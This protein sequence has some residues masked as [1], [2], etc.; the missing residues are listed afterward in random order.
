[1][2]LT[3][4]VLLMALSAMADRV[5][6]TPFGKAITVPSV[7]VVTPVGM[8]ITNAW[9]NPGILY[10]STNGIIWWKI[11]EGTNE[12]WNPNIEVGQ[13]WNTNISNQIFPPCFIKVS[14]YYPTNIQE[15]GFDQLTVDGVDSIYYFYSVVAPTINGPWGNKTLVFVENNPSYFATHQIVTTNRLNWHK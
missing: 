10:T 1:M 14:S 13:G 7:A 4:L 15:A 9:Q 6:I 8:T 2:K 11:G 12:A 5:V 3:L